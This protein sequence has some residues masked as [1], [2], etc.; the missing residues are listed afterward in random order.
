MICSS[1]SLMEQEQERTG[2]TKQL[3]DKF[4]LFLFQQRS[5]RS[6][7]SGPLRRISS[8]WTTTTSATGLPTIEPSLVRRDHSSTIKPIHDCPSSRYST[9]Y[10]SD[11]LLAKC[12]S[13][14]CFATSLKNVFFS[15]CSLSLT[16]SSRKTHL[17]QRI[18]S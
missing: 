7:P 1:T 17:I 10:N 3:L 15:L 5:R 4:D 11:V 6:L 18:F 9:N 8:S 13:L 14:A 16:L 12:E 2:K